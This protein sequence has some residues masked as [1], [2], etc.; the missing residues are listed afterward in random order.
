MS[1]LLNH[2]WYIIVAL[3]DFC[4]YCA[5]FQC[6]WFH[7]HDTYYITIHR[8]S[9]PYIGSECIK[10]KVR[11]EKW[12]ETKMKLFTYSCSC[13]VESTRKSSH[14]R[15]EIR[16]MNVY[17]EKGHFCYKSFDVSLKRTQTFN[18]STW[19]RNEW[20][21]G[22]LDWMDAW[23]CLM[24]VGGEKIVKIEMSRIDMTCKLYKKRF[25]IAFLCDLLNLKFYFKFFFY[26]KARSMT[27]TNIHNIVCMDRIFK[28]R[29]SIFHQK[30]L[31]LAFFFEGDVSRSFSTLAMYPMTDRIPLSKRRQKL[32]QYFISSFQLNGIFSFFFRLLFEKFLLPQCAAVHL[33]YLIMSSA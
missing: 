20:V 8:K 15:G 7:I 13:S 30:Q 23:E 26:A 28:D 5:F 22:I 31:R 21:K 24:N 29:K 11:G 32:K 4:S 1:N 2:A 27:N 33:M 10:Y 6:T 3:S 14:D 16:K 25:I 12:V 9:F 19:E 17:E 18:F